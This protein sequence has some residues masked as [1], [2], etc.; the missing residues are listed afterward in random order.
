M[1]G[2]ILFYGWRWWVA[3]GFEESGGVSRSPLSGSELNY[4]RRVGK[5]AAGET[6]LDR[7]KNENEGLGASSVWWAKITRVIF[8]NDTCETL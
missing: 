4:K 3:E 7:Q 1:N 2:V 6:K 5:S 8:L